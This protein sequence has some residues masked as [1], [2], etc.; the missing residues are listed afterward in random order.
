MISKE[1]ELNDIENKKRTE[2]SKLDI[3][4]KKIKQNLELLEE[5][6]I[7]LK[8]LNSSLT[9]YKNTLLN[10]NERFNNNTDKIDE[11]IE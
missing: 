6:N 9:E 11:L 10:I 1:Q 5:E 8:E 2:K 3:I 4:S 7:S